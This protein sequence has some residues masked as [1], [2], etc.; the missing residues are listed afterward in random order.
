QREVSSLL[1][2]H[3]DAILEP[4]A[5]RAA[6]QLIEAPDSLEPDQSLGPYRIDSFLA[7]G[8]MGKVYRAT[9]TRLHRQVAIKICAAR[10]SERFEREARVIA[11]LNHPHICQLYDV[12]PNYLVMELV[13]GPTLA[14]R[15]RRGALPLDEALGIGCQIA[16]A[17]EAAHEKGRVH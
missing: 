15:I 14:D 4:W 16:D 2:N 1:A 6:A 7:A 3:R 11:S 5:A 12:G 9:D 13:E 17:L 8:G 10:F